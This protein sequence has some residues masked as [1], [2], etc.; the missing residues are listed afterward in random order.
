MS[1]PDYDYGDVLRRALHAAAESV[2]PSA[3]GLERI[4]ERIA[5]PSLLSFALVAGWYADLSGRAMAWARPVG[6]SLVDLFW[7]TVDRFRPA[8][9]GQ[10]R[11][12]YAWLRPAA[13]MGTAI[14]VV[15]A[16]AFAVM[17]LP[18]AIS[19]SGSIS[20]PW[21]QHAAGTGAGSSAVH[22]AS[23]LA[24]HGGSGGPSGTYGGSSSASSSRCVSPGQSTSPSPSPST[25]SSS[26]PASTAS[27]TPTAPVT[28][29]PPVTTTGPSPSTSESGT[30][31]PGSAT[32]PSPSTSAATSVTST[33]LG[34][35][36]G[37][38]AAAA[39]A[40]GDAISIASALQAPHA[41][42]KPSPSASP[43]P[44]GTPRK[45]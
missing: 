40:T 11:S 26:S 31:G 4:R 24:S 39:A 6:E 38:Q 15:A 27:T 30:P 1:A 41:S 16:G 25:S 34:L 23:Q 9:P 33:V 14:F 44:S 2:D 22:S 8:G 19:S 45:R 42:K 13:A 21:S 32:T 35:A 29:S 36:A 43:C 5:P 17:T 18:Q 20:L 28:S 3:E 10:A 7:V 37:P 12:R